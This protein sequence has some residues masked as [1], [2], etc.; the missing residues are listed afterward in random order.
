MNALRTL[1]VGALAL[2]VVVLAVLLLRGPD[3]A[4]P[5][6]TPRVGMP[7][8]DAIPEE[9]ALQPPQAP[10]LQAR[11]GS[12]SPERQEVSDRLGDLTVRV[13]DAATDGPLPAVP[14][15]LRRVGAAAPV[16]RTSGANGACRFEAL[17]PGEY[18]LRAQADGD[19]DYV[20]DVMQLDVAE[21]ADEEIL[22]RVERR[23]FLAGVVVE[24]GSE[25]PV[26]GVTL[27]AADSQGKGSSMAT[28]DD[29]G[30]FRSRR[31]YPAG[32][33]D[34]FLAD[35]WTRGLTRTR[36]EGSELLQVEV[37]QQDCR[38]LTVEIDWYGVLEG[39]VLDER[40]RPI[41]GADVRVLAV[42]SIYVDNPSLRYWRWSKVLDG[43]GGRTALSDD[44]GR[45]SV[46]RLPND[47]VLLATASAPGFTYGRSADL[48]PPFRP[49]DEA[50]VVRLAAGGTLTGIVLDAQGDPLERAIVTAL[51]KDADYQPDPRLTGEDGLFRLESL[52]AG[53]TE[54][55]A[56]VWGDDGRIH[57]V[58][59]G[60]V[61]VLAG[62]EVELVLQAGTDG[63]HI[64]GIAVDQDGRR[65]TSDRKRL[66][67]RATP[68]DPHPGE[69]AWGHDTPVADD[70]TFDVTVAREG[71]YRLALL[72]HA[73]GDLW[74]SQEVTAPAQDVRLTFTLRPSCQLTVR[75]LD[76]R[77]GET[78]PTGSYSLSSGR[79]S[80][81]GNFSGGR[82]VATVQEGLYTVSM[83]AR[84]YASVSQELDLSGPLQPEVVVEMLL[85]R[86]QPVSGRVVDGAGQPVKGC[87]VVLF[88]G[89]HLDMENSTHTD[90]EGR[91][92]IPSAPV[93]G[94][95]VWVIDE[96]YRALATAEVGAG[97]VLL[98]VEEP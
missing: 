32:R 35:G 56:Q 64:T 82:V 4:S 85:E 26:A 78:I 86:G 18:V 59:S 98:T 50:V 5:A 43:M 7:V 10:E 68:L 11:G 15:Q 39:I 23:W 14:V 93:S 57:A 27:A 69:A 28:S 92:T 8:P 76:A 58:A 75:A 51:S 81:G 13:L 54:V 34:L 94:A 49:G 1:L 90:A 73:A 46:D 42:E 67:V 16:E 84:G 44:E 60:T 33:L 30:R 61:E 20:C 79:G 66:R 36:E 22:L 65:I 3:D 53:R 48:S 25:R 9:S 24:R 29:A 40:D 80:Y 55:T 83:S 62:Q 12:S 19:L 38:Q 97:E 77:T 89:S 96:S 41:A 31:S 6:A 52:K 72:S 95:Q 37:G 21:N 17:E 47:R 87:T 70:G 88:T 91:F 63:V 2:S 45:F 74:E 71:T